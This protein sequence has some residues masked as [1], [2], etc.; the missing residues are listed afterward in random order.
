M[1]FIKI[2]LVINIF[3][4]TYSGKSFPQFSSVSAQEKKISKNKNIREK[5]NVGVSIGAGSSNIYGVNLDL[6]IRNLNIELSTIAFVPIVLGIKI[7]FTPKDNFSFYTGI[8][9]TPFFNGVVYFPIGVQYI[10]DNGFSISAD[11][12]ILNIDSYYFSDC[13]KENRKFGPWG[14]VKLGFYF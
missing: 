10:T 4:F 8:H 9:I 2:I 7:F 1:R 12:G 3:L 6:F 13:E 14:G 5:Y 11:V